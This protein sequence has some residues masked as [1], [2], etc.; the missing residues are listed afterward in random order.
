M[1]K[2]NWI[3]AEVTVLKFEYHLVVSRDE[4][5]ANV[6][7]LT[8]F[9]CNCLRL[10]QLAILW[11]FSLPSSDRLPGDDAAI[12]AAMALLRMGTEQYPE[13]KWEKSLLRC[14][15][16]L[17][18]VL[19]KSKH[20]YDAL[21]LL[22]RLYMYLGIGS[23]AIER[24]HQMSIKNLQSVTVSWILFGRLSTIHPYPVTTSGVDME[25][26]TIDP[27]KEMVNILRW[28]VQA[29]K[30]D[31]QAL[32]SMQTNNQWLSMLSCIKTKE[33]I[34]SGLTI[35]MLLGEA[36]RVRRLRYLNQEMPFGDEML[37]LPIPMRDTRDKSAFPNYEAAGQR[38]CEECLPV[39]ESSWQEP[40]GML[41]VSN[42]DQAYIWDY[43]NG[44]RGTAIAWDG[45][46]AFAASV[47]DDS[48]GRTSSE[49]VVYEICHRL[50]S[51]INI[52]RNQ[53]AEKNWAG[54]IN[55][56][57]ISCLSS[58][59]RLYSIVMN[60]P[61]LQSLP[62]APSTQDGPL[63]HPC[64]S[65]IHT[66]FIY[67]ELCQF[68]HLFVKEVFEIERK[69][70]KPLASWLKT[71]L[72]DLAKR[73]SDLATLV[74][75]KA[76]SCR[77]EIKKQAYFDKLHNQLFDDDEVG[78]ALAGLLAGPLTPRTFCA[79]LSSGWVDALDGVIRT[80]VFE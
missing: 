13:I 73:N 39:A 25:K 5:T 30:L 36:C 26:K 79:M 50:K 49:K 8:A 1:S 31:D 29:L 18:A 80:K 77:A 38:T 55:N 69:D 37:R 51:T 71:M 61:G 4:N 65:L 21:L 68:G 15:I 45:L 2:L 63:E 23:L 59:L 41:I 34:G 75:E 14:I 58:T 43:M 11:D 52:I 40:Q 44:S 60:D 42:L 78:Q 70:G 24:Y 74:W 10:Y 16:I 64:W 76:T 66:M 22:V 19:T 72:D 27:L 7:L 57:T 32:L 17:E 33:A 12:L 48:E 54:E 3:T 46:N 35:P 67:L 28:H 9:V 56:R 47:H 20:N 62:C 53:V 6:E